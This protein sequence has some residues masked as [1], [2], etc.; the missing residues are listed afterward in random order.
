MKDGRHDSDLQ[1]INEPGVDGLEPFSGGGC[2]KSGAGDGKFF[3][4]Y[5]ADRPA[6]QELALTVLVSPCIQSVKGEKEVN[7]HCRGRSFAAPCSWAWQ[8]Y[9]DATMSS[10]E[11]VN[12]WVRR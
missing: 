12:R 10:L 1:T 6:G 4:S 2:L 8:V 11:I 7:K 9:P 5:E 3:L